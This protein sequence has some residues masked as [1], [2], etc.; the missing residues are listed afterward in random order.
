MLEA[1]GFDAVI[2]FGLRSGSVGMGLPE[3]EVRAGGVSDDAEPAKAGDLLS[4]FHDF[5]AEADDFFVGDVDIIDEDVGEP[6]GGGSGDG[7][8]HHAA[9]RA[10]IGGPEGGVDHAAAHVVV[11]GLPVEEGGVEGFCFGD[12]GGGEFDV[13]EGISHAVSF[14]CGVVVRGPC[15][16]CGF[17]WNR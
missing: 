4:V 6:G 17:T 8:L 16:R 1:F 13:T 15:V 5:A 12:V 14:V 10:V 9:A 7:M 3:A 2:L 11:G